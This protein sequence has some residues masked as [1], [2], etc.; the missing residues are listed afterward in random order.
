M[1]MPDAGGDGPNAYLET[2]VPN[3]RDG[4]QTVEDTPQKAVSATSWSDDS[5]IKELDLRGQSLK[6]PD[7]LETSKEALAR[8]LTE[9]HISC[10]TVSSTLRFLEENEGS[11]LAERVVR[12]GGLPRTYLE[13]HGNWVSSDYVTDWTRHVC[14]ELTGLQELPELSHPHWQHYREAGRQ[15]M[16]AKYLGP[17][18]WVLRALG[19]A[20]VLYAQL[21]R[22]VERANRTISMRVIKRGAGK[23]NIEV[24]PKR[25]GAFGCAH[26]WNTR[27]ILETIPTIWKGP[28]ARVEHTTCMHDPVVPSEACLYR[29]SFQDRLLSRILNMIAP[30][31]LTACGAGT[32]ALMT[33]ATPLLGAS[34]G[35]AVVAAL[36]GWQRAFQSNQRRLRD[37]QELESALEQADQNVQRLWEEKQRHHRALL[38]SRKLSGY[39]SAELVEQVLKS[40]DTAPT[41]G[42]EEVDA[43][44]L[45]ADIVGFTARSENIK[46]AQVVQELNHYFSYIDPVIE[47]F[48][49][50]LDKRMG[51]G[52]MVVFVPREHEDPVDARRRA[53]RCGLALLRTVQ[54]Q[55]PLGAALGIAPLQIR[56]GIAAGPTVRG[57]LGSHTQIEYTIIGDTVNLSSRLENSAR[58]GRL[59]VTKN[60]FDAAKGLDLEATKITREESIQVRGRDQAQDTVELAVDPRQDATSTPAD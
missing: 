13:N 45:F 43:A 15:S 7:R 57:N 34:V 25:P 33:P 35:G 56:V 26:C 36:I 47:R 49:G 59:M 19:S 24:K 60:V 23:I 30:P 21:P 50:V 27:G 3:D 1:S 54:E 31:L 29:V 42:G 39:L 48:D 58:P 38:T 22:Q 14:A 12:L 17:I 2:N 20:S 40:P 46:P 8:D 52:I 44:V 32:A 4:K 28:E 5:V 11:E 6:Q 41:L 10:R 16:Q 37:M 55:N 18:F 51:D 9:P 53:L